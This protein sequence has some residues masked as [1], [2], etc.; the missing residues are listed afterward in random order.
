MKPHLQNGICLIIPCRTKLCLELDDFKQVLLGRLEDGVDF[1][2]VDVAG[3]PPGVGVVVHGGGSRLHGH[4]L[5]Q[6]RLQ[7]TENSINRKSL[8]INRVSKVVRV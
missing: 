7:G 3:V 1:A 4:T 8:F 2:V 5:L 6:D